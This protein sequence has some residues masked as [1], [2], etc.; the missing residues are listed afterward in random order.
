MPFQSVKGERN[1]RFDRQRTDKKKKV[2]GTYRK[3]NPL[4]TVKQ[5]QKERE[6]GE[7]SVHE[8]E[9]KESSVIVEGKKDEGEAAAKKR[10]SLRGTVS[11]ERLREKLRFCSEGVQIERAGYSSWNE[12]GLR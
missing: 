8:G 1:K 11:T 3:E 9:S 4:Y 10:E 5:N 2:E 12:K 7:L 6:T